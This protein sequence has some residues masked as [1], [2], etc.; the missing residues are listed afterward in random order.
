MNKNTG[1]AN[2]INDGTDKM[3]TRF[4]TAGLLT[5][6]QVV[7]VMEL[8]NA[9]NIRFGEAA[10]RLGLLSEQDVQAVLSKQFNYATALPSAN[11]DASLEIAHAPFSLEAEAI[12]QI[13]AEL[14]IRLGDESKIS[15]A[16]VS[17]NEGEGKSYLAASL[18]IA[19]S[20]TGKRTLLIDANM[21][22]PRQQTLFGI[23]GKTGLSTIL[24]GRTS[25]DAGEIPASFPLLHVLCAGPKPPNP[26]EILA[27]P[28]LSDLI[29]KLHDDFDVFIVDTPPANTSSDAQAIAQQVGVCLLVGQQHVSTLSNLR[30][31]QEQMKTA[32]AQVIGT[33]YNSYSNR[34]TAAAAGT[35]RWSRLRQWLAHI[36]NR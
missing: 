24:A 16:I 11:I 6:I 20:Q 32:G 12:R 29:A 23:S 30:R 8:Q 25:V 21:R 22:A 14:G 28:A 34:N 36:R 13:R 7:R 4:I 33:I 2:V 17:P 18:A 10:V 15:L 9:E 35:Q 27:K 1:H 26:L 19:F 31:T 5:E 3:G